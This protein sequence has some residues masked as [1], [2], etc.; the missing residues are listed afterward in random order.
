MTKV[1]GSQSVARIERDVDRLLERMIKGRFWTLD[2][3]S[4]SAATGQLPSVAAHRITLIGDIRA[5]ASQQRVTTQRQVFVRACEAQLIETGAD[6]TFRVG[7]LGRARLKRREGGEDGFRL[8]HHVRGTRRFHQSTAGERVLDVDHGESPLAWLRKRK[9]RDGQPL[10][11]AWQFE[12]GER[13]RADA[14]FGRIG[15][16]LAKP[17]WQGLLTGSGGGAR[18]A[19]GLADLTDA[20]IAARARV[21]TALCH[22]GPDLSKVL[23]DVCCD[24]KGLEHIEKARGWPP[25]T[26]KVV[27]GI[28]LTSLARHYGLLPPPSRRMS[29]G[30]T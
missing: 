4:D 12:A 8:Q 7:S 22:V 6:D 1:P 11:N 14:T 16:G 27:L 28:A 9:G 26:G 23:V 5:G 30:G 24:L 29:S 10:I 13:L 18:P 3:Q 15:P 19:G 17:S 21:E 25:R 2:P 20:A